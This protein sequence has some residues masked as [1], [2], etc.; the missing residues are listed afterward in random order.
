[1]IATM[2]LAL[3]LDLVIYVVGRAITP[4]TRVREARA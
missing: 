4:W 1:M 2:A 3:F